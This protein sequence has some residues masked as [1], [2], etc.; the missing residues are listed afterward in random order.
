MSNNKDE[1]EIIPLPPITHPDSHLD[2]APGACGSGIP[3]A[4]FNPDPDD[5]EEDPK[6]ASG[7]GVY[8]YA[9]GGLTIFGERT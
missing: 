7:D 3:P 4:D 1:S 8:A 6:L 2:E 5:D 9:E